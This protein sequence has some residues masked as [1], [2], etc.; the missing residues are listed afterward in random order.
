VLPDDAKN[1]SRRVV[2]FDN[3][4]SSVIRVFAD[5]FLP[6]LPELNNE[7]SFG[8]VQSFFA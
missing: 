3:L 5:L 2:F 7:I 6:F 4:R 8:L 1:F